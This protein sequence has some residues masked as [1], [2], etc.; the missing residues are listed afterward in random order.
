MVRIDSTFMDAAPNLRVISG[1]G[2]GYNNTD[3]DSA[4]E[5]G[6]LVCNTPGVLTDAVADLTLGLIL[7]FSRRLIENAV[8]VR[9]G[10]WGTMPPPPLGFDLRGKTLG[11]IGFGRI[12]LAVAER[13]HAFGLDVVFHDMFQ[14]PPAGY[15][16]CLY[17]SLD[18]L[19][20][21]S[22]IVTIHTNL[23]PETH[24]LIST[25]ELALMKPTALIVNTARGPVID[26]RALYAALRDGRLAGAALDVLE[27][28]PPAP[29]DP[30]LRLPNVLA[31][32]H[33]GSATTETRAAMLDV[34]VR[35]LVEALGGHEP[36]ASV[37]PEVLPRALVSRRAFTI[38]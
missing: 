6:I 4:T 30:L 3:I 37:N 10:G 9:D 20:R 23:S 26:Q 1:F 16:D 27:D 34:A 33:V 12:G 35:N 36:P 13:A 14:T 19:L 24:H 22:D 7:S 15:G 17:L 28:E 8:Y 25:R 21:R 18:D 31:L 5:R 2:V 11:I 29:D 32:P 38:S